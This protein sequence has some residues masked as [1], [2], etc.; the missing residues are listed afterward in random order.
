MPSGYAQ[1]GLKHLI[2]PHQHA[3]QFI[4]SETSL[5]QRVQW[6]MQQN[7]DILGCLW[8]RKMRWE[9]LWHLLTVQKSLHDMRLR[10]YPC[11]E[12]S[13]LYY[14]MNRHLI[15]NNLTLN[16]CKI[17][18]TQF[19]TDNKTLT[20]KSVSVF[21][22]YTRSSSSSLSSYIRHGVGPLVDPFRSHVSRSLFKGLP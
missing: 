10:N 15:A 20:G 3:W 16:F 8:Q 7:L 17:H 12:P 9:S 13:M 19:I 1:H 21:S 18:F 5:M 4:A 14:I 6:L 2:L 11:R 22:V